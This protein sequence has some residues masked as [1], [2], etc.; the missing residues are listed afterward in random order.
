MVF[1]DRERFTDAHR[2][3]TKAITP[4]VAPLMIAELLTS[5]VLAV[6]PLPHVPSWNFALGLALTVLIWF[7]TFFVQVPVHSSLAGGFDESLIRR[8][9]RTNL[10]RTAAWSA[11]TLICASALWLLLSV[12][13]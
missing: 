10:I 13:L 9:V 1:I 4:V 2:F 6:A 7:S 3:H 12:R 5:C 11:R 8:L